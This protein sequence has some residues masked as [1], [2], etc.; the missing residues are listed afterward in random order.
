MMK[1]S[2]K[3]WWMIGG[4]GVS[5]MSIGAFVFFN[6]R[7]KQQK[8]RQ[9][10]ISMPSNNSQ[11]VSI[12][13]TAATRQVPNWDNAFDMNYTREVQHWLKPKSIVLLNAQ[14]AQKYAKQL[15][16][17]NGR[18]NDDE[19]AIEAIFSKQLKDKTNVSSIS[20]AFWELYKKDMWQFLASFLSPTEMNRYV[21]KHVKALPNY[22]IA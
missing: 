15:K 20:K 12:A 19:A 14:S 1:L 16:E 22:T 10:N 21:S 11:P 17:A 2:K 8:N 9:T 7:L 6:R 3:T 18:F 13:R 4:V 5:A